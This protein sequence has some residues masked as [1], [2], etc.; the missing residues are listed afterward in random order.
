MRDAFYKL[1]H[2]MSMVLG[3]PR[4]VS[5]AVTWKARTTGLFNLG[6]EVYGWFTN[7]GV[8]RASCA[9]LSERLPLGKEPVVVDLGCGPGVSAIELAR[10]RPDAQLVGLDVAPRML[11]EARR[12]LRTAGLPPGLVQ[13]VL[14]DAAR[15]P[16][17]SDTV[18][19]L[20][21]HSFLYLL[22]DREAVL[23]EAM[24]V[25][26]P[27]GRLILM[28]PHERPARLNAVLRLSRDPRH[29]IAVMLWRPFSRVHGRFTSASLGA[30][31]SAAGFV[32]CRVEETLGGLGLLASAEKPSA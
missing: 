2:R 26:R 27:G 16:F 8:W 6:A 3:T 17:P 19:A 21:G 28:E 20:T 5:A 22:P 12:R 11:G 24:R 23:A 13:L 32:N 14:G 1:D 31:L 4:V 15:L 18:D 29:L 7:Q 9:G 30:T 10:L 25:L